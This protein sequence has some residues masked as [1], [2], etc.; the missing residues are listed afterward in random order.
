MRTLQRRRAKRGMY[1]ASTVAYPRTINQIGEIKSNENEKPVKKLSFEEE[2]EAFIASERIKA[3]NA[4]KEKE[5]EA[6][7]AP[8]QSYVLTE[9]PETAEPIKVEVVEEPA[10]EEAVVEP[11]KKTRK[12]KVE[13]T[14]EA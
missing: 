4:L 13:V 2:Y 7:L 14:E 11:V 12:S 1:S 5:P 3:A 9:V 10:T 8:E 6:V